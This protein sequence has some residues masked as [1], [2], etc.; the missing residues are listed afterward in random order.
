MRRVTQRIFRTGLVCLQLGVVV[1][2]NL[3]GVQAASSPLVIVGLQSAGSNSAAAEIIELANVSSTVVSLDAVRVEYFSATPKSFDKPSR[4]ITLQGSL[5]PGQLYRLATTEA[6]D[7]RADQIFTS[8]LAAAGGHL[9]IMGSAGQYDLLG[10][11][12]ATRP[13]GSA[14]VAPGPGQR[15][16]RHQQE[17]TYSNT[18]NNAADFTVQIKGDIPNESEKSAN[19]SVLQLSEIFPDPAPPLSDAADEFIELYN[20]SSKEVD[21]AGLQLRVGTSASKT[22]AILHQTI[23]AGGYVALSSASTKLTLG[24]KGSRIQLLYQQTI[25]DE[26]NYPA[27]QP[28]RSWA[29]SESGWR[30]TLSPTIGAANTIT[31]DAGSEV[32]AINKSVKS[33]KKSSPSSLKKTSPKKSSNGRVAAAATNTA[34]QSTQTTV[35]KLPVHNGVI[36][37]VG[38]LAVLYGAYEY[39]HDAL[40]LIRK[41]RRH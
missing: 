5:Q 39:R 14:A 25:L 36:A 18:G 37:G 12:T 41:L 10:W 20:S 31:E 40:T 7:A 26:T 19:M 27:A 23:P 13:Q 24:N 28:G 2:T 22:F 35:Q 29:R 16:T 17:G 11:G 21:L 6:Q 15:L 30:W 8:T 3:S 38:G 9:K 32:S 1:T 34:A 33:P 4:S